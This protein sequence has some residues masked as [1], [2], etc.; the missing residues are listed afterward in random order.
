MLSDRPM[1]VGAN[2]Y[3]VAANSGGYNAAAGIP[4]DNFSAFVHNVYWLV[5]AETGYFGLIAFLFLLFRP[6]FVAILCGSSNRRDKRGQ[7][8]IGLGGALLVAY[9]HSMF[10]WILIKNM[11]EYLLS[12]EFGMIASLTTQLGYWR[13]APVRTA[14]GEPTVTV[15]PLR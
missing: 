5:A 4:W 12:I 10:E 8:L 6:M 7:L 15:R 9:L 3:V 13:S 1:G 2:M 14:V 11:P